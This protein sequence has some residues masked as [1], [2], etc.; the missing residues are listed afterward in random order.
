M[1]GIKIHNTNKSI[2]V[3]N[4][5]C[6]GKNYYEHIE[7]LGGNAKPGEPIIFLKPNSSVIHN[8]ETVSIPVIN[9]KSISNDLQQELELVIVISKNGKD[10]SEENAKDFI[11][12][13]AIGLDMTLRD[14]QSEAKKN[15]NPWAVSKGFFTSA[16]VSEIILKKLVKDPMNLELSLFINE[17]RKQIINTGLMLFNIYKLISYISSVFSIQKG[18]LI[19]TGTPKGVSKLKRNDVI[20]AKLDKYI[21]LEVRVN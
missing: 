16:P 2:K 13:Y 6:V 7:E 15:G 5:F 14:V 1:P 4:I 21:N 12:G 8:K 18:D 17:I 19:F 20:K 3:N 11:L 10:I 9:K